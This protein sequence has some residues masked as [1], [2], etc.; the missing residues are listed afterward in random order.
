MITRKRRAKDMK[1]I[2]KIRMTLMMFAL[3][4]GLMNVG[5]LKAQ[6]A[7]PSVDKSVT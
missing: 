3:M 1:K 4:F 7:S 2:R 6:A 5:A